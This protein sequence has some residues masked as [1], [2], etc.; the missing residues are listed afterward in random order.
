MEVKVKEKYD[1]YNKRDVMAHMNIMM[2]FVDLAVL[3]RCTAK[4]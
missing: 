2:N 4:K 3:E 1:E